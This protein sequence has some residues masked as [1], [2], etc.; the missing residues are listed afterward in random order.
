MPK[1]EVQE[2]NFFALL[3]WTPGREE[4]EGLLTGAKAELDEWQPGEGLIK[5]EL[6]D[7]NRPD[8]W[9]AP[10]LAR[11]LRV[12]RDEP[13][14]EYPFF[15]RPGAARETGERVVEVDAALR[16][17]RPYIAA[18]VAQGVPISEPQL[19]D[20]IESQEK[21]CGNF[22]RR[23]S[24]IAMGVYRADLM[25]FPVRYRAADPDATA[26]VPLGFSRKLSLRRILSEH[27]KGVEFGRIVA[28]FE[29]FPYLEDAGGE[30]LS[31]PPIINSARLG[32][33]AVGDAAHFVELT[34]TD[35]DTLLLACSIVAC[36][37]ADMGYTILPVRVSYP[38]ET[39]CGR[40]VVTPFYFQTE[41]S[42][43][44]GE[45]ARL[46]G[47]RINVEEALECLRRAGAPARSSGSM[48]TVSPPPYRN[49]FLHPVDV[50]EEVMIGRGMDSFEPV[51]PE[52]FTVGRLAPMEELSRQ[53]R[54]LL[55]G[56]GYQEMIYNY[57]G[58]RRDFV[59]RMNLEASAAEEIIEIANPMSESFALVRNSQLPS[60]L[61]TEAVSSHAMYP[62]R[63]FEVGKIARLDARDNY[64]SVTLNAVSFLYSDREVTFN[65]VNAHLAALFFYLGVEHSLEEVEDPRFVSGRTGAVMA[66]GR[67]IGIVGE[68]HPE[69]LERWGIQMPCAAVEL[70]LDGILET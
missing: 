7:T 46:L 58:S 39:P 59:E 66:G 53:V 20:L 18:F 44:V 45:A 8:L 17:I 56:L 47:E 13:L 36:D 42:V 43:E 62:H 11:Q 52:D 9:S 21:L 35:M 50:I 48:L 19:I 69:V 32:E 70:E 4:L 67:R 27:P 6:N 22:G 65:E 41:L 64:G 34:G 24:T 54:A 23:R 38:F 30:T 28:A 25:R 2:R 57:L 55:A 10:G 16:S 33:V 60:L 26:F 1:I 29:R 63:T 5:F 31:F 14:P 61:S 3:G 49:D 51:W 37:L 12:L 68:V 40:E 15:S